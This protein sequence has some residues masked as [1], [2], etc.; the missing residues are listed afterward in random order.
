MPEGP[1]LVILKDAVQQFKGK[2]ILE[3]AGNTKIGKERL[4]NQ[5]ITD[6]RT[7]GKH[8]LICFKT[9]ALRVHLMLFGSYRIDDDSKPNPR[10]ALKFRNGNL[11]LYACSLKYIDE[12]LDEVYEWSADVMS[13]TWN[14][15]KAKKK[16]KAQPDMLACDA[17][18][19]QNIFSGSGNI[20]KCEVLF[21]TRI[22]PASTVGSLPDKK[23]K[24]LI[25][26]TRN[27]SFDFLK[28]KREYVLKKHWQIYTKKECPRCQIKTIKEV[29]GK[30]QRRTFYC[31]NCQLLYD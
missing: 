22:H 4:E 17:L 31:H 13:D 30:T 3:V 10:L 21:R 1:S 29:M 23:L 25:D 5:V 26:E 16:L 24:E 12:P 15:K 8:F 7:W 19:D 2:R 14:A 11:N 27:Y 6:F 9:F 28:W 20:I 18:L